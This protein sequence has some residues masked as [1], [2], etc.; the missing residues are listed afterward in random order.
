MFYLKK[1][2]NKKRFFYNQQE[3]KKLRLKFLFI[4]LLNHKKYLKDETSFLKVSKYLIRKNNILTSKV[5]LVRRCIFNN[6][7]R[8][9]LR[10]F[11]ISRVL[12]KDLFLAGII[13]G[14]KKSSW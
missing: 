5:K 2:E 10:K 3:I 6:R 14:L 7:S 4:N 8:G 13:P 11:N 9:S 1:K 12:L